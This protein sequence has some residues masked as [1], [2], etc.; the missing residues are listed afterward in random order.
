MLVSEYE[1][2]HNP[3]ERSSLVS[4]IYYCSLLD[5]A[6]FFVNHAKGLPDVP[7]SQPLRHRYT[8]AS[9]LFSWIALEEMLDYAIE[10]QG[11]LAAAPPKPLR[12]RLDFALHAIGRPAVEAEAFSTARKLRNRLTHPVINGKAA[13]AS[14]ED[15]RKVFDFCSRAIKSLF[16]HEVRWGLDDSS[17]AT[18]FRENVRLLADH[19]G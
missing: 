18:I 14:I 19:G 5:D 13:G 6:I 3:E 2:I 8:R 15:A 17:T 11:L 1:G 9:I 12:S 4:V 10:E 7:S 16:T